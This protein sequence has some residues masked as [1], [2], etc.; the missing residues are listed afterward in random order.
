M[1]FW[2]K[3]YRVEEDGKI[4]RLAGKGR[5]NEFT[6]KFFNSCWNKEDE[7]TKIVNPFS[8]FHGKCHILEVFVENNEH[9]FKDIDID[10]FEHVLSSIGIIPKLLNNK[11]EKLLF[12]LSLLVAFFITLIFKKIG[13]V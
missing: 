10:G 9:V 11:T 4:F 2:E 6:T 1:N 7:L 3:F 13:F 5:K 8:E 12:W